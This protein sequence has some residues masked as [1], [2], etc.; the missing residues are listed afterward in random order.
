MRQTLSSIHHILRRMQDENRNAGWRIQWIPS[1]PLGRPEYVYNTPLTTSVQLLGMA[2]FFVGS[3]CLI[4]SKSRT[5]AWLVLSVMGF[6]LILLARLYAAW[7]KH[8][9]WIC[10][11]AH[12]LDREVRL[13]RNTYRSGASQIWEIRLL[14]EFSIS[15]KTYRATPQTSHTL[16]FRSK[17]EA[18]KHLEKFILPDGR[19]KLWVR[20]QNPLEASF[21]ERRRV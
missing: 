14:C 5:V 15:G 12:C 21:P 13:R 20:P 3:T 8:R 18:E 17:E 6:G 7:H 9:D 1:Q 16:A 11:P 10:I 19:C 2:L 4:V